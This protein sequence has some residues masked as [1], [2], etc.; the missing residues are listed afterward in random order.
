MKKALILFAIITFAGKGYGQLF[1][2]SFGST[3][4]GCNTTGNAVTTTNATV[5][6][7]S[8]A[9]LT[10]E[11]GNVNF[12]SS[13]WTVSASAAPTDISGIT[14]YIEV[15][16]TPQSG[17]QL[18]LSMVNFA[19]W[20]SAAGPTTAWISHDLSGNFNDNKKDFTPSNSGSITSSTSQYSWDFTD[21]TTTNA[22]KFRIYAWGVT[23][24]GGG[25]ATTAGTMRID[26]F[27]VIGAVTPVGGNSGNNFTPFTFDLPNGLVGLGK[28][29]TQKLDVSGNTRVSKLFVGAVDDAKITTLAANTTDNY[30]LAVTGTALFNRARVK[31]YGNWADYVFEDKYP[32]L[33]LNSLEQYIRKHKHLPELPSASDVEKDGIDVGST[34]TVLLKKI[35]ELT[36]YTID[37]HKNAETQQNKIQQLQKQNDQLQQQIDE[38]RK[39]II[40]KQ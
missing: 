24:A 37:Q 4:A 40:G 1:T 13:N 39:L 19:A 27:S 7:F 33:P 18:S 31:L 9:N 30:V 34:Q 32:L 14:K 6:A 17:Y 29:P 10:C 3:D 25:T 16:I 22:V 26:K 38:L 20:K 12:N 8:R 5:S 2:F 23:S 21:F 35:E 15:T 11:T 36:L 28:T